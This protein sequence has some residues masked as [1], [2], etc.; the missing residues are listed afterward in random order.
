ML[1]FIEKKET[2]RERKSEPMVATDTRN[3][4]DRAEEPSKFILCEGEQSPIYAL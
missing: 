3:R 1:R 4:K 2:W